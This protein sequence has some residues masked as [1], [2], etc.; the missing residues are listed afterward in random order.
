M[1]QL[2][3]AEEWVATDTLLTTFLTAGQQGFPGRRMQTF[4]WGFIIYDIF[5]SISIFAP[6]NPDV[7]TVYFYI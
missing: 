3:T 7:I 2:S 6:C 1:I 4:E 5:V